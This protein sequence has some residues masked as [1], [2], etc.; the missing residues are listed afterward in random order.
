MPGLDRLAPSGEPKI[1]AAL[2]GVF[3]DEGISVHTAAEVTAMLGDQ[4]G[5][6]L[7]VV[8]SEANGT[9][10]R[11]AAEQLLVATGRRAITAG[12]GLDQA[13]VKTGGHG[14]TIID[15]HLQT[16]DPRICAVGDVTG[17]PQLAYVAAAHSTLG[18]RQRARPGGPDP[19]LHHAVAGDVHQLP[20]PWP[21]STRP[22]PSR[23]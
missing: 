8:T 2:A 5:Y 6:A 9:P 1:S 20:L 18:R 23:R 7:T 4:A 15:K 10:L 16:G 22:A 11:L 17:H 21:G 3:A 14:E 12:P 19:G 13:G